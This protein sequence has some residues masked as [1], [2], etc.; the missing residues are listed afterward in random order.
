MK[1][2]QR[3]KQQAARKRQAEGG[4]TKRELKR[5]RAAGEPLPKLPKKKK[6]LQPEKAPTETQAI[7]TG[8]S[9]NHDL[10]IIPIF[11]RNIEG[12]EDAMVKEA[13]RIKS[14]LQKQGGLDVWVDRTHKLA[15]GQKLNFW[16]SQG[17]RWRVELGPKEAV[18]HRCVISHQRGKAGD[19]STVTKLPNVSTVKVAQ[20]LGKLREGLG[21]DK[22]PAEAVLMAA[23]D[24]ENDAKQLTMANENLKCMV[25]PTG[26]SGEAAAIAAAEQK[27][28]TPSARSD[29]RQ[30]SVH[31]V[32]APTKVEAKEVETKPKPVDQ[33]NAKERRAFLRAQK[34]HENGD[35]LDDLGVDEED[36]NPKKKAKKVGAVVKF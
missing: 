6:E 1:N 26:N 3:L 14:I 24:I 28:S 36:E 18:K 16:E 29:V 13:V 30:K 17:V 27:P 11:W 12:Q 22:I 4:L 33:M 31:P 25:E 20:L 10:V 15:P 9:R 19:F 34:Q 8:P 23:K 21:L 5:R 32:I 7:A 2:A 35:A